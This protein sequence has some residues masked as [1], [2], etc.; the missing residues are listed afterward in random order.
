MRR[1]VAG[2]HYSL[3]A[4]LTRNRAPPGPAD[5]CLQ[6][7]ATT[8]P[9]RVGVPT[10][11]RDHTT[12]PH[13]SSQP[14]PQRPCSP[15]PRVPSSRSSLRSAHRLG[16]VRFI[17]IS[18]FLNFLNSLRFLLTL[19]SAGLCW[20]P[21]LSVTNLW[22]R[23]CNLWEPGRVEGFLLFAPRAGFLRCFQRLRVEP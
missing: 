8:D 3:C 20:L 5:I 15:T 7:Q 10:R 11:G 19:T 4:T 16:K 9:C 1:S 21:P 2:Q 6:A 12:P 23:R 17:G 14:A 18:N 22:F 13:H